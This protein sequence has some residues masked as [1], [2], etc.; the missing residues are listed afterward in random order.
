MSFWVHPIVRHNGKAKGITHIC[1]VH[2]SMGINQNLID[3]NLDEPEF[4]YR[5]LVEAR[6]KLQKE[7]KK[8][9]KKSWEKEKPER[10]NGRKG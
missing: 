2:T 3:G 9:K 8:M 6:G 1:P 7:L 10:L 4:Y 5:P